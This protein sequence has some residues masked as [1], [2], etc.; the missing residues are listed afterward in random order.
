MH[1][2]TLRR[3]VLVTLLTT[4]LA[5]AAEATAFAD[6]SSRQQSSELA[7]KKKKKPTIK[8]STLDLGDILVDAK[9]KTLYLYTPDGDNIEESQ[10]TG[11]CASAWPPLTAK[12]ARVGKG[13]DASFATVSGSTQ[14]AY[15]NHLL[16]RYGGDSAAGDTNGQGIG[17]VWFAVG[18]DGSPISG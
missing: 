2:R 14:V 6:S 7:K 13:L 18:S 3:V 12:K 8:V 5:V 9:G 15:N 4:G 11:G 10:C 1:R 17:G 16:Y